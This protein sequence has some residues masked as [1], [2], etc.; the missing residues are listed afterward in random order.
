MGFFKKSNKSTENNQPH[1]GKWSR[2][3]ISGGYTSILSATGQ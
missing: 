3:L 2:I 1:L